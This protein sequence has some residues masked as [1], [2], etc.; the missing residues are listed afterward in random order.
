MY[1]NGMVIVWKRYGIY[2]SVHGGREMRLMKS[3]YRCLLQYVGI[4]RSFARL[5][6]FSFGF[7]WAVSCGW[8]RGEL[9]E[10]IR[11]TSEKE[12]TAWISR[13]F[14]ISSLRL[15]VINTGSSIA[16]WLICK[17]HSYKFNK[18]AEKDSAYKRRTLIYKVTHKERLVRW[19]VEECCVS[20]DMG[21][22]DY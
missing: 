10:Y 15:G 21:E 11:G 7:S 3:R 9:V 22:E 1:G 20:V 5:V 2:E 8:W 13:G 6:S 19:L 12:C 18:A 14:F 17:S 16:L 4:G